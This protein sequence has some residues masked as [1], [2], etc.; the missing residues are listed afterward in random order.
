ML[1]GQKMGTFWGTQVLHRLILGKHD[2]SYCLKP[3]GNRALIFGMFFPCIVLVCIV[4]FSFASISLKKREL[5]T[6]LSLYSCCYVAVLDQCIFL[7][8]LGWSVVCECD[9]FWSN[10]FFE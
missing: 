5:D 4:V 1:L 9:T 2:K 3:Q 7:S 10:H 6:S 8:V